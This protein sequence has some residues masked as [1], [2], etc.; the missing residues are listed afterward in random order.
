[1]YGLSN[2]MYLTRAKVLYVEDEEV[3]RES[4][5]RFL[6][7]RLKYLYLASNGKDG[8]ALYVEHKP[9][10]VITDIRMP[11][12]DGLEMAAGIK[13]LN[14]DVPI[15]VTTA[16]NEEEYFLKSI[17]IGV[18]KF[19][20]KPINNKDLLN[21]LSKVA[22]SVSQQKEIEA[23]NKFIKTIL[24]NNPAFVM[25]TDGEEILFLNKSFLNYLGCAS[26][27]DFLA[28]YK[29]I[30]KFLITKE[31]VFYKDKPFNVWIKDVLENPN[32]EHM[33]YMT[34]R[35]L[36][37]TDALTYLVRINEIPEENE[38]SSFLVTFTDISRIE[39][40][41]LML[42]ELSVRDP[43][44]GIYNRKKFDDEL[45]KEIERT[46]RYGLALSLIIFDIDH[47]KLVNDTHGHQIGDMV[48]R[49]IT[50]VVRADIRII[51]VFARYGGEEFVII[52]PETG[53]AGAGELAEKLRGAVEAHCFEKAGKITC[54]FGVSEYVLKEDPE[55]LIRKADYALY[56]AKRNG[57]NR[58]EIIEKGHS[59]VF[60]MPK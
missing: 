46:Q 12:M 4:I 10:V 51:D 43:L 54:S 11:L 9:D 6:R 38:K 19:I 14:E 31:D 32:R 20:K 42:Q 1:M 47:F 49:E 55:G 17:D 52:T 41:M 58:V 16:Y 5:A 39:C 23:K 53:Q 15:I 30:N 21:A 40:E 18:D 28:R 35:D 24:D 13:A 50:R 44:T 37:K 2:D 8:L 33:V 25:I 36:L 27:D 34:G 29:T 59:L 45:T 26:V 7:R 57:R 60:N 3:I 56:I 48:L 22:R